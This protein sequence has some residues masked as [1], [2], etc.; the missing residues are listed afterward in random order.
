MSQY[1]ETRITWHNIALY[2]KVHLSHKKCS[3]QEFYLSLQIQISE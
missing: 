2:G 3:E 1:Q